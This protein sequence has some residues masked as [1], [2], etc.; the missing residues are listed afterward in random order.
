M[1]SAAEHRMVSPLLAAH[2]QGR[3]RL[4]TE[5]VTTLGVWE[6]E[7]RATRPRLWRTIGEVQERL[8]PL[9]A[10]VA[11]LKGVA[12]EARW[13]DAPGQR[14]TND[15]DVLLAPAAHAR[16]AEVVAALDPGHGRLPEVERLV[17]ARLLQHVDLR[18]GGTQ[19]DLHFDPFKVGV[20]TRRLDDVWAGTEP[21]ETASGTIRVLPP[22]AELVLLLLHL[23]K[24]RFSYLGPFLDVARLLA[25]ADLDHEALGRLVH[26]EGWEV[27][28]WRSLA[29]VVGTLGLAA[30]VP[31]V[32]GPRAV[33]WDR[34][35]APRTRLRGHE[36]RARARS[37]Q[38]WFALH[39]R[40]RPA[41][42]L[43]EL[44][45]QLLPPPD[46]RRVAT[47]PRHAEVDP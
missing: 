46:L 21:L 47:G 28:V 12:T 42:V 19:V 32:S 38:R 4:P 30:D 22:E 9:G 26:D 15:V 44:Q 3:I 6:L 2:E 36:G 39:V 1:A 20:P 24:D 45:R 29:V 16:A 18:V 34:L 23:N 25:R 7:E 13:Y 8:G 17:R 40:R 27:P 5:A 11:V 33:L 14:T 43:R 37:A 35:W 10:E 41:D 31:G